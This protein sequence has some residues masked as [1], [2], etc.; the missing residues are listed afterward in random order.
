[1]ESNSS[2]L[3]QAIRRALACAFLFAASGVDAAMLY[4]A[5]P[6]GG[7]EI[8]YHHLSSVPSLMRSARL[9]PVEINE[10]T[11][12]EPHQ[13]FA[14][15]LRD[16]AKGELLSNARL[17]TWRYLVLHGETGIAEVRLNADE[18]VGPILRFNGTGS[19]PTADAPVQALKAAE[20][21]PQ[22]KE[23]DYQ[24]RYVELA[25]PPFFRAL[26]LQRPQE[27]ILI[28]I[29]DRFIKPLKANEAYSEG[30]VLKVLKP[31]AEEILEGFKKAGPGAVG[32]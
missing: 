24:L 22:V 32:G 7:K 21:L 1:M 25:G 23:K 16:V 20:K 14:V 8:A 31:M 19:S 2:H 12:S 5:P 11:L 13:T 6:K 17:F 26:W 30:E 15:D 10:M 27:D 29:D 9:K 3:H 18:K 28:P 4:P